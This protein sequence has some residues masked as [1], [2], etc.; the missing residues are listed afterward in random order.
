MAVVHTLADRL[1][2]EEGLVDKRFYPLS[3][4]GHVQARIDEM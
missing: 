4:V 1:D 3:H 2:V